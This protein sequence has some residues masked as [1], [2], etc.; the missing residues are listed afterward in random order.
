MITPEQIAGLQALAPSL[1][2]QGL[3]I[4][5]IFYIIKGNLRLPR[6]IDALKEQLEDAKKQRDKYEA[7]AWEATVVANRSA[8]A[9]E[10]AVEK[11]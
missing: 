1:T 5:G 9:A 4:L 6:E 3:L 11:T 2:V 7:L 10:K 8:R